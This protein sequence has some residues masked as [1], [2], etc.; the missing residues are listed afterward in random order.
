M[1][2]RLLRLIH[3]NFPATHWDQNGWEAPGFMVPLMLQSSG[4]DSEY[5]NIV[6]G[7]GAW[8][9]P[10][11]RVES[12]LLNGQRSD[13]WPEDEVAAFVHCGDDRRPGGADMLDKEVPSHSFRLADFRRLPHIYLRLHYDGFPD[14]IPTVEAVVDFP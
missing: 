13:G 8:R 14:G 2:R 10:V 9:S 6:G 1:T 7:F 5:L 3:P 4:R 11:V 12:I